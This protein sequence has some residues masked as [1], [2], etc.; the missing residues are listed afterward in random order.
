MNKVRASWV[1]A[2]SVRMK[3]NLQSVFILV[4]LV[5]LALPSYGE[6][7]AYDSSPQADQQEVV[8][9][10]KNQKGPGKE[11]KQGGK[12][13]GKGAA[14]GSKDLAVG[15]GKSAGDLVTGHPVD[16]ATSLGKGAAGFGKN[17][18]VGAGKG[19]VKIGKGAVGATK[20]LGRKIKGKKKE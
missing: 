15:T 17:A 7:W 14:K 2:R 6:P 19:G 16:A 13:I 20:K 9:K 8:K 3:G 1:K 12:D 11:M 5:G 18:G 4:F 10:E